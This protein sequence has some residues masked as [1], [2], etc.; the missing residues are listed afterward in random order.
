MRNEGLLDIKLIW[1][2]L[3]RANLRRR[4]IPWWRDGT[5]AGTGPPW[6]DLFSRCAVIASSFA[7]WQRELRSLQ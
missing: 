7:S 5:D 2:R 6:L 1:L 4:R 3:A